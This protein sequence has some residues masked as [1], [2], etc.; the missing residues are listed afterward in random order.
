MK[1][2]TKNGGYTLVELL[3]TLVII[4]VLVGA[5]TTFIMAGVKVYGQSDQEVEIQQEAQ[6]TMNILNDRLI[7]AT[8]ISYYEYTEKS[9]GTIKIID[10]KTMNDTDTN[11]REFI[12]WVEKRKMIYVITKENSY[13]FEGTST[14]I[15]ALYT[16]ID[17]END[18]IGKAV[19]RM[20][21]NCSGVSDKQMMEIVLE[22]Q[23]GKCSFINSKVIRLRNQQD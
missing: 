11:V 23:S 6:I 5:I 19:E 18:L 17:E 7:S 10:Y 4:C 20:D 8:H 1:I 9:A 21:V 14:Q 13:M 3:V 12:M 16:S 15:Q 22:F 2:T